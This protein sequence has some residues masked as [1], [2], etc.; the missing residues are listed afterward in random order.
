MAVI[1][2]GQLR[3]GLARGQRLIGLDPGSRTIGVALSD[4]SLMIASPHAAL[5]RTRLAVNAAKPPATGRARFRKPPACP[6]PC[7]TNGCPPPPSTAS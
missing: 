1:N 4:V 3:A 2:I 6:P 7:G 5:R